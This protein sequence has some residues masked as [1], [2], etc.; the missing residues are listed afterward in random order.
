M[1]LMVAKRDENPAV[2]LERDDSVDS[3]DDIPPGDDVFVL[4]GMVRKV[5]TYFV[6]KTAKAIAHRFLRERG[7]RWNEAL[8]RWARN[9]DGHKGKIVINV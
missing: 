8:G 7:F 5:P 2:V 9:G 4:T 1:Y 3:V 6:S